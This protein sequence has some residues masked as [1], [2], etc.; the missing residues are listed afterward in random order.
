MDIFT[1]K[2]NYIFDEASSY[3]K[4]KN[5]P[6]KRI[7]VNNTWIDRNKNKLFTRAINSLNKV[8]G[9]T[10][11]ISIKEAKQEIDKIVRNTENMTSVQVYKYTY[12]KYIF[13]FKHYKGSNEDDGWIYKK[14]EI[15]PVSGCNN[16]LLWNHG[17]NI[18]T[19]TMPGGTP[20]GHIIYLIHKLSELLR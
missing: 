18:K 2:E 5:C 15:D 16:R 12:K 9:Q 11:N 10:K 3:S 4:L 17:D 7:A 14:G 8:L 19:R 1:K 13:V 20:E 6:D